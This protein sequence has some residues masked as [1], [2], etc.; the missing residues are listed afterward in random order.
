MAPPSIHLIE[1]LPTKD[2]EQLTQLLSLP[3]GKLP[4]E[5]WLKDQSTKVSD[6]SSQLLKPIDMLLRLG[7]SMSSSPDKATLCKSHKNLN[8]YLI[9][10]IFLQIS[11]ECTTRLARLLENPFIDTEI[12]RHV[13]RLQ[14]LNSLW[15]S[16]D[17]YRVTY[18]VMPQ[19]PR[20]FRVPSDCEACILAAVGG[21]PHTL[22]DLR[23]S[24]L[25][26][27]KKRGKEPRLLRLV[28]S[29]IRWTGIGQELTAESY[30]LAR[31]VRACRRD[32][33]LARR[34][35]KRNQQE[36]IFDEP[37]S[38]LFSGAI[39]EEQ[40]LVAEG[41]SEKFELPDNTWEDDD[42]DDDPEGDIIGHYAYSIRSSATALRRPAAH[43]D[44]HTAFG[45]S[46]P[47][48]RTGTSSTARPSTPR[49]PPSMSTSYASITTIHPDRL[50]AEN[51]RRFDDL[52]PRPERPQNRST[53]MDS[54]SSARMSRSSAAVPPLRPHQAPAYTASEYS[55]DIYGRR[56]GDA[57]S[58]ATGHLKHANVEQARA[59]TEMM[60]RQAE[61]ESAAEGNLQNWQGNDEEELDAPPI[62][63]RSE[64][65][66]T[67]W[68][69]FAGRRASRQTRQD[70]W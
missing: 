61:E 26:R 20:F 50:S 53:Y 16:V 32:M 29:W 46:I 63:K 60:R 49:P 10:R 2:I 39:S 12:Q 33:Q 43:D 35:T 66:E 30:I 7:M 15:M 31:E 6:L 45:K 19:E 40:T 55:R 44:I 5:A 58:M 70:G 3:P 48:L 68:S 4:T 27:K 36:G 59:Y 9:R 47:P 38:P 37:T 67:V 54:L 14:M 13:K 42:E 65:R 17:L 57:R 52:P 69:D 41:G 23:S 21:N 64:N 56:P 18:Q 24:M 25:G 62:P 34:Q 8:P 22:C 28:E 51:L 11:A 1:K